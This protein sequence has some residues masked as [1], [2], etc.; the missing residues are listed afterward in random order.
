MYPPCIFCSVMNSVVCCCCVL[1]PPPPPP[2]LIHRLADSPLNW[3]TTNK[4]TLPPT[5]ASP[6][7]GVCW[8]L[9]CG[10]YRNLSPYLSSSSFFF[11]FLSCFPF[12]SLPSL[13]FK[14]AGGGKGLSAPPR[15]QYYWSPLLF[16]LFFSSSSFSFSIPSFF[17]WR[18]RGGGVGGEAR[19]FCPPPPRS[20]TCLRKIA[21]D[22]PLLFFSS[23]SFFPSL[24]VLFSF[25]LSLSL[26][27]S[28]FFAGGEG[29][30]RQQ[31]RRQ[32]P[33][34]SPFTFS[35]TS[36]FFPILSSFPFHF[37]SFSLSLSLS[38]G[39]GG[40]RGGGGGTRHLRPP[41]SAPA[42]RCIVASLRVQMAISWCKQVQKGCQRIW[43]RWLG[44]TLEIA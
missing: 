18:G 13:S 33:F 9:V 10:K 40:G 2:P 38:F 25:F 4:C 30:E 19:A 21:T 36:S 22:I 24:Y 8:L 26:L 41:G 42:W 14:F 34:G 31:L 16:T 23:S 27:L 6:P 32:G 43:V 17:F 39:G 15:P 35:F 28:L 37:F 11:P 12:P 3:E 5:P 1:T 44:F 29:A 20:T 7:K